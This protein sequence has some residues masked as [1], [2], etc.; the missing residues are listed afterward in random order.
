MEDQAK[1]EK[2]LVEK[3][4]RNINSLLSDEKLFLDVNT[5]KQI[6]DLL[7]GGIKINGEYVPVELKKLDAA[8]NNVRKL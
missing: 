1:V 2:S 8:I 4:S 5:F 3:V 6:F 7:G